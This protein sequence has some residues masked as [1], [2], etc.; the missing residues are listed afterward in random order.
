MD[1]NITDPSFFYKD[2]FFAGP[3]LKVS[4]LPFR[5]LCLENGADGVFG[6]A[7]NSE[8]VLASQIDENNIFYLGHPSKNEI[9]FRT[10]PIEK[11]KLVF[12][13]FSNDSAKTIKAVER[14]YPYVS[15]IDI[16]CGCPSNFATSHGRGSAIMETPEL[17]Y[18][19]LSSL[20]RNFPS[21][22]PLSVKFRVFEEDGNSSET[23]VDNSVVQ[24]NDS[25]KLTRSVEKT[26]QFAQAC[27][28][29][30]ASAV[31]LH[32][33]PAKNRHKGEVKYEEMKIVFDHIKNIAKVGN[34]G[35][36]SRSDGY[37]IMSKIGCHSVM[38]SSEA[39]RNPK[40]FQNSEDETSFSS[41]VALS[42]ASR[43][44]DICIEKRCSMNEC[45]FCLLEMLGKQDDIKNTVGYRRLNNAKTVDSLRQFI[46]DESL[47]N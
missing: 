30:G 2:K 15:A 39:L 13:L 32:G 43:F 19:I 14:I 3:M 11:G 45:R 8:A 31:I 22:L 5:L 23:V 20:R 36:K 47:F 25:I 26:I 12:Q 7:I 24:I 33:R 42:N 28:N 1:Q 4:N 29:S 35:I 46:S 10:D 34:G 37:E 9:L 44:L 27:E 17:I 40:V 6:P 21:T 16:N 38:I 41:S 18:D